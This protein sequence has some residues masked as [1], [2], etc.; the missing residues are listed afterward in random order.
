MTSCLRLTRVA[1]A[2]GSES[3][4]V[5]DGRRLPDQLEPNG[6]LERA[7]AGV[8]AGVGRQIWSFGS[9]GSG[10]CALKCLHQSSSPS[11][12]AIGG[13]HGDGPSLI[14]RPAFQ[15]ATPKIK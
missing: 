15:V 2:D 3:R 12:E 8:L 1:R 9:A 5:Q 10:S 7:V 13:P 11:A 4:C 14:D 6:E